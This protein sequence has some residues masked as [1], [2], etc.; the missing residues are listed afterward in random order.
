M[1]GVT[2]G[3]I[4]PRLAEIA[5][6]DVVAGSATLT[7]GTFGTTGGRREGSDILWDIEH[8][9]RNVPAEL[10]DYSVCGFRPL[11]KWLSYCV[12]RPLSVAEREEFTKLARRIAATLLL[13]NDADRLFAAASAQPLEADAQGD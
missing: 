5:I 11:S 6:P 12:Q 13:S 2:S 10:W 3:S 7:A 1:I 9:W 8:G 4:D